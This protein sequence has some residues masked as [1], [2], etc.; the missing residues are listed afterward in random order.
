MNR[1][2][3]F[4]GLEDEQPW[5]QWLERVAASANH[6]DPYTMWSLQTAFRQHLRQGG[7]ALQWMDFLVELD[8]PYDEATSPLRRSVPAIYAAP[9][10]GSRRCARHVTVRLPVPPSMARLAESVWWL[11]LQPQVHR[12]QIG[13]PRAAFPGEVLPPAA[14]L[15]PRRRDPPP[16]PKVLLGALEDG[17]PFGHAALQGMR[18]TR[19]AALWDQSLTDS[20]RRPAAGGPGLWPRARA[21]GAAGADRRSQRRA[22]RRRAHA[23]RRP[24]SAAAGAA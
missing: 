14:E 8:A 4:D 6:I 18:G 3:S 1:A 5:D 20:C 24:A 21:G 17:C 7:A 22:R 19:V 9:M 13:F 16:R 12:A 2:A 11:V 10:P 15:P 23:V